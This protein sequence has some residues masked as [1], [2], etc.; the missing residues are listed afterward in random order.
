MNQASTMFTKEFKMNSI[1]ADGK[2]VRTTVPRD[3]ITREM[4]RRGI[5]LKELLSTTKLKWSYNGSEGISVS[6]V[7]IK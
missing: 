1:G 3:L 5:T 6:F 4:N 2:T 7:L